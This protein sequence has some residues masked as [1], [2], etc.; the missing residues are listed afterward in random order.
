MNM[1]S[2]ELFNIFTFKSAILFSV[3]QE[4]LKIILLV[5]TYREMIKELQNI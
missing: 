5:P 4:S 3:C 1:G 2:L